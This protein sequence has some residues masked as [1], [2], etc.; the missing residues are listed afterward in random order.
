MINENIYALYGTKI[1]IFQRTLKEFA[2]LILSADTFN[3]FLPEQARDVFF[4]KAI[5][6]L[7]MQDIS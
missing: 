2:K 7:Q 5:T 4:A 3:Y 1:D 6:L